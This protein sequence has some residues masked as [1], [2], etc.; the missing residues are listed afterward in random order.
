MGCGIYEVA[1][2]RIYQIW[3]GRELDR[4]LDTL[5]PAPGTP[6]TFT[7]EAGSAIGRLDI[8]RLGFSVVVL[9]GSDN[10]TL[11]LGIGRLRNSALPSERGN[12]VLAGHRDTFFRSL[13][14][15][16]PGDQ[17]S[18]RTPEG[19]FAYTVDWTKV[20][21]PTDTSVLM[22]TKSAALTLVT[23]YPFYYVGAAPER[24]IVRAVPAGTMSKADPSQRRPS[25]FGEAPKPAMAVAAA[26]ISGSPPADL[27][28]ANQLS[29]TRRTTPA[30]FLAEDPT[31]PEPVEQPHPGP[32]KRAF[33]K[34]AGVFSTHHDKL[35]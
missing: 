34:I 13:R 28:D 26:S 15:I 35:Q 10:A 21:N 25:P 9:E 5:P 6:R 23:C 8:P 30:A 11:R 2:G 14:E 31:A 16:L 1:S 17:I 12:V 19:T 20:V 7:Y 22:P 24:F 18:L 33:H 3:K 4:A 29:S 27:S 32:L